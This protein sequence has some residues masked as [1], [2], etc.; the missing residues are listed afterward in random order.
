MNSSAV[1][2][3]PLGGGLADL[4][5]PIFKLALH[6]DKEPADLEAATL[7][8]RFDDALKEFESGATRLNVPLG[9][10]RLAKYAMIAFIDQK[11]LTSN[12]A[13]KD[14]WLEKPLQM[15]Y[16]DDFNAG[17]EFYNKLDELR[18]QGDPGR[19]DA[20]EVFYLC[21]VLG[22]TGKF[23]DKRGEEQRRILIDRLGREIADSRQGALKDLSP[24][25]Q[26]SAKSGAGGTAWWLRAPAWAPPAAAIVVL[27]LL[28]LLLSTLLIGQAENFP[29][30]TLST[31]VP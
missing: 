14:A 16:F 8:A 26:R 5:G 21:L 20:A 31:T 3:V 7:A 17:E 15:T 25:W 13:L 1:P 10:I 29:A 9:N 4:S 23:G 22:F 2:S 18:N 19:F 30:T 11:V 24:S 28:W 12:L 27:L 6:L